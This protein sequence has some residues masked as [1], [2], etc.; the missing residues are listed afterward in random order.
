V[1]Y[2]GDADIEADVRGLRD[3]GA[4]VVV[5]LPH[6]GLEY[7]QKPESGTVATAR[8]MVAAGV[9]VVLGSH[10]H[11]VQ[12]VEFVEVETQDGGTRRGLVAYSLGNF[13]SNQGKRHTESGIVLEF[14]LAEEEGGGFTVEDVRVL[15]TFCWRRDE[16]IQALPALQYYDAPPAGMDDATWQ[17]LR[18]SCDDLRAL[19]GRDIPLAAR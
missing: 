10:P 9:D 2:L 4:E 3:A 12:P 5:A 19:M 1:N 8:R 18:E 11:M 6:W 17:R 7:R 14:T 15:P 13:I 16:A